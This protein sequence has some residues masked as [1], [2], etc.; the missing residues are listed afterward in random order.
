VFAA[1]AAIPTLDADQVRRASQAFV[2][3]AFCAAG[4]VAIELLS[5]GRS[6]ARR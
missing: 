6:R 5:D 1:S 3:G 2:A 4:F